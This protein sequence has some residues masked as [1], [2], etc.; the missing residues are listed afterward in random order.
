MRMGKENQYRATKEVAWST[1]GLQEIGS[2]N[3]AACAD[4]GFS[5]PTFFVRN[6]YVYKY[7]HINT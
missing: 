7:T 1:R 3:T 2:V 5:A 4:D 6:V